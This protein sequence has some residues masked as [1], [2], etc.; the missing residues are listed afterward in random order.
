M[1]NFKMS[2]IDCGTWIVRSTV[3]FVGELDFVTLFQD[4][5]N[6]TDSIPTRF[7]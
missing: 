2:E 5:K 7:V 6:K 3:M 1:C 4:L